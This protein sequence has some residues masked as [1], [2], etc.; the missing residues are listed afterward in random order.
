MFADEVSGAGAEPLN[1]QGV[2][3]MVAVPRWATLSL[4]LSEVNED[5][6]NGLSLEGE[7]IVGTDM[8]YER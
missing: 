3:A 2:P 5:W 8:L 6:L 4:T 7:L 1:I